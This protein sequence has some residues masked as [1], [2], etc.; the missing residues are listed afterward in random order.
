MKEDKGKSTGNKIIKDMTKLVDA[1]PSLVE[2][3][4]V[5]V[6]LETNIYVTNVYESIEEQHP[7]GNITESPDSA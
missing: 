4:N 7:P 5:T 1:I 6:V 3:D 2:V